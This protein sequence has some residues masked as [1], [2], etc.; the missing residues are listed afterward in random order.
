MSPRLADLAS[1][2]TAV[3]GCGREARSL[4]RA[5]E[6]RYPGTR[7]SVFAEQAPDNP[8]ADCEP[9]IG[10]FDERLGEFRYI[11]RS[12]GVPVDR[13]ALS[14]AR[15]AG[16]VVVTT[17]DLW[18]AERPDARVL[19]VTG[20][21]GKSTTAALIA[22]LLA[23]SGL[24]TVLAG[25]IGVPVLDHLDSRAD[26]FV[27]ELSSFQLADL[28]GRLDIGV[29]TR[30]FPEH[31]DWH[32]DEP[33]YFAAKLRL[34][35]RLEGGPLV[36]NAV[37]PVLMEATAGYSRRVAA[38]RAPE[39]RATSD[40]VYLADLRL[41]SPGDTPLLGRHN[42]DNIAVALAACRQADVDPVDAA[43]CL[44]GFRPLAHRLEMLDTGDGRSWIN[45]SIATTPEATLAALKTLAG[46]S[47][48]LLAGG[49]ERRADWSAVWAWL[50]DHPLAALV[51]LPDNG[52][53]I[54]AEARSAGD[55]ARHVSVAAELDEAIG[56]ARALAAGDGVILL[57][58][59]APSF[60]RFRDFEDRGRCFRE[61]V[62]AEA[63]AG[64]VSPQ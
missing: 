20:S 38:N 63:A 46:R 18:R 2:P 60:P 57:S 36:V 44:A 6:A 59:G 50:R 19:A 39:P 14:A 52:E 58:P 32:G 25:N 53:R 29:I 28:R 8:P 62:M 26:W 47:I 48:V 33:A 10:P 16:C 56:R 43:G 15:D 22:H 13:P 9:L 23:A 37:D 11:V 34:L 41:V 1:A 40:G 4:L 51:A 61:G 49:L 55:V 3:L 5:L 21:K 42:L 12:P 17:T 24:R 27:L 7:V 45:D 31:L 64:K 35:E 30:L 54:A